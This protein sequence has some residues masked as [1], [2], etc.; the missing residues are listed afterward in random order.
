MA[1]GL[2]GLGP[3]PLLAG[4][5]Q[6]AVFWLLNGGV[7]GVAVSIIAGSAAGLRLA[8]LAPLAASLLFMAAIARRVRGG[9]AQ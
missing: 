4:W 1:P 9:V 2:M 8:V 3:A 6:P 5:S 7:A